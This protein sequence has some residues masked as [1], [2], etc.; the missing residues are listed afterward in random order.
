MD[1][2]MAIGTSGTDSAEVPPVFFLMANK[3]WGCQMSSFQWKWAVAVLFNRKDRTLKSFRRMAVRATLNPP[4]AGKIAFMVIRVAIGT[5]LM[6][7]WIGQV[8]FM[9][10]TAGQ[11][12]MLV[13]QREPGKGMVE[14]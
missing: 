12:C 4:L 6:L 3:A 13:L 7:Q 1:I 9:T 8:T 2:L 14:S 10:G 5:F 11:D